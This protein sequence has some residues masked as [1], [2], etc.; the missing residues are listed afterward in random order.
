MPEL[1]TNHD[2]L[3]RVQS[4]DREATERAH[5]KYM[6]FLE[7]TDLSELVTAY[8]VTNLFYPRKTPTVYRG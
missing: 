2:L 4:G 6:A 5:E 7:S 8:L 1:K 3:F